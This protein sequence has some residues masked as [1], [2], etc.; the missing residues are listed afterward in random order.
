MWDSRDTGVKVPRLIS[1]IIRAYD[2]F[3]YRRSAQYFPAA[4]Y[5]AAGGAADS[6][7][8]GLKKLADQGMAEVPATFGLGGIEAKGGI[9]RD[10][11]LNLVTLRDIVTIAKEES[12]GKKEIDKR[13]SREESL[14]LQRYLLGLA[15]VSLTWFDGRTL[16]LRQGCQLVAVAGKPMTRLCVNAN[17]TDKEFQIDRDVAVEYAR[18]TARAFGVEKVPEARF[19]PKEAKNALKKKASEEAG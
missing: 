8:K 5:A 17:G 18:E 11:S 3:E 19:D 4:D 2:V 15:L 10:A 16:N 9:C 7:E 13:R 14:K 6:G 1:S 12:A